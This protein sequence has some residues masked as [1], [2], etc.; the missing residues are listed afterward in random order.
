MMG[1]ACN[2]GGN[3][4]HRDGKEVGGNGCLGTQLYPCTIPHGASLYV[5]LPGEHGGT[6]TGFDFVL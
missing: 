5:P 4:G 1:L 6:D 3:A 2:L